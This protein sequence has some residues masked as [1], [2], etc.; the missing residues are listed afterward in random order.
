MFAGGIIDDLP[1]QLK[2][3]GITHKWLTDMARMT[4]MTRMARTVARVARWLA[5]LV[6][7]FLLLSLSLCT[8]VY[9]WLPAIL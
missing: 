7:P 4:R 1:D 8:E 6:D 2:K 3:N 9:K 5:D